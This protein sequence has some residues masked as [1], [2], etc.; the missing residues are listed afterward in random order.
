MALKEADAS[1]RKYI[2]YHN[3]SEIY[4]VSCLKALF[5]TFLYENVYTLLLYLS[6]C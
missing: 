1:L 5:T 3:I 2:I 6:K 4:E